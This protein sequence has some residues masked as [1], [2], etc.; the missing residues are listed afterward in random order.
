MTQPLSDAILPSRLIDARRPAEWCLNRVAAEPRYEQDRR[1][2]SGRAGGPRQDGTL[3]KPAG[4]GNLRVNHLGA[5]PL[6]ADHRGQ[7]GLD[8]GFLSPAP[9]L[10]PHPIAGAQPGEAPIEVD[11]VREPLAIEGDHLVTH[12]QPC[13][14]KR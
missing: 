14:M 9:H 1:L 12:A 10:Q 4:V 3:S 6:L 5:G 11:L 7:H 2:S 8:A 13:G